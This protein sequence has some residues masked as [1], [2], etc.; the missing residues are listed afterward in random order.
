MPEAET[1]P[2]WTFNPVSAFRKYLS[3]E[4]HFKFALVF[5]EVTV[6]KTMRKYLPLIA[7]A[8]TNLCS[9]SSIT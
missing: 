2:Q 7:F 5:M 9:A 4:N 6:G 3:P 1:I 8:L